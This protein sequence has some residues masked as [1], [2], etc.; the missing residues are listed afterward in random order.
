MPQEEY[1]KILS[2]CHFS[3]YG[4]HFGSQRIALKVLQSGFFWPTLFKD[5]H[6]I[7][8]S[9]DICQRVG[10]IS[11]RNEI[12]LNNILKVEIFDVWGIDFIGPFPP[13]FGNVYIL[14]DVG[15]VS[16]RVEVIATLKNDAKTVVKF[17]H[18]ILTRSS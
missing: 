3:P 17:V 16:K 18:N 14:L 4:G 13:L 15:Y 5:C 8:Q 1:E 6:R 7:V 12:P 9:C 2:K 11:R 10:K